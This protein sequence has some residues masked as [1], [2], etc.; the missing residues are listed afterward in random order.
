L[1]SGVALVT[2]GA[3][4]T[5]GTGWAGCAG[6]ASG[7]SRTLWALLTLRALWAL[8]AVGGG[9]VVKE[10]IL[11]GALGIE[12]IWGNVGSWVDGIN[13]SNRV[14]YVSTNPE[15]YA[16]DTSTNYIDTN[17]SV[18]GNGYITE[19][20]LSDT[21]PWAFAPKATGGSS[22]TYIP[23]SSAT[24]TGWTVAISGGSYSSGATAGLFALPQP[25]K[26][27]EFAN[28]AISR[29]YGTTRLIG[30][31]MLGFLATQFIASIHPEHIV[32]QL[33]AQRLELEPR[34]VDML[35]NGRIQ[36]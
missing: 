36:L 24:A 18:S 35:Q 4:C 32:I 3:L 34:L 21:V 25:E 26:R 12:N 11:G 10:V 33:A 14:V 23:D 30:L 28:T 2:L 19:F 27:M 16:D 22:T 15:D 6:C 9:D 13:F 8:D 1:L 17:V 5:L 20:D 7:A 29:A 31:I